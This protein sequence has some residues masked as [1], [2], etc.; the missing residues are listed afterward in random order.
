MK[1]IGKLTAAVLVLC[2]AFA[3]TACGSF[4]ELFVDENDTSSGVYAVVYDKDSTDEVLSEISEVSFMKS[5]LRNELKAYDL[6]FEVTLSFDLETSNEAS[7]SFYYYHS[8]ENEDADDYCKIGNAY[9]GTYTMEGDKITFKFEPDGYN[10]AFYYVGSDY[11]GS[12]IFRSFSYAE[13]GSCGVWGYANTTYE[14]ENIAEITEDVVKDLPSAI[15]VT[16]SGRK[17]VSW[18]AI[19]E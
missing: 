17:I 13:D 6:S 4:Y 8:R 9:L 1:L 15:E 11:A 5:D 18:K 10:M 3:M 19:E 16:V 12:D 14:Y 2:C 7:L